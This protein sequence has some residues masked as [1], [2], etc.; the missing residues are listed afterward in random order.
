MFEQIFPNS[1][2]S[3]SLRVE[4]I[5]KLDQ[6]A[7]FLIYCHGILSSID[8]CISLWPEMLFTTQKVDW[9]IPNA[10]YNYFYHRYYFNFQYRPALF[11]Q[12]SQS[13][14]IGKVLKRLAGSYNLSQTSIVKPINFSTFQITH[15][16]FA[17][18][19]VEDGL[20]TFIDVFGSSFE[21][22]QINK[23]FMIFLE[24]YERCWPKYWISLS[25]EEKNMWHKY[26]VA[27]N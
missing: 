21:F 20:N 22:E 11:L 2:N 23:I 6:Y 27:M 26:V 19:D 1:P 13:G 24:K 5:E 18:L 9:D 8:R 25:I 4:P 10:P 7:H 17:Y 12:N 3:L 15:T 14:E 16:F